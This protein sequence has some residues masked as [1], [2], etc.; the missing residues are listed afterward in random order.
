MLY[1]VLSLYL[2]LC[3]VQCRQR[4]QN[5]GSYPFSWF[6]RSLLSHLQLENVDLMGK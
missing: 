6:S 4:R 2:T 5:R 1:D 3:K